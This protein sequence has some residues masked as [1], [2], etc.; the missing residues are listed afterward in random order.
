MIALHHLRTVEDDLADLALRQFGFAIVKADDLHFHI[1]QG[2]ANGA[3]L[4]HAF[5]RIAVR[6]GRRFGESVAFDQ[7]AARQFFEL[8]LCLAHQRRGTGDT[9]LD[10]GQVIFA[11]LHRRE[12][13]DAV[14]QGWHTG[15]DGCLVFLKIV[16]HILQIARIGY[17]HHGGARRHRKVHARHHAIHVE[18]RNRHQHDLVAFIEFR[19][20]RADL[21][22]VGDYVAVHRHGAL[23]DAR[24]PARILEQS[25]I[26]RTHS[27]VRF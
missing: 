13:V 17:H 20:E 19:H 15:E 4:V 21:Q 11:F 7:L 10:G 5:E 3:G 8:F 18:K 27:H 26:V 16:Q 1:G 2:H 12:V 24:R 14:V 9:C 25:R 22:C 6:G 23:G